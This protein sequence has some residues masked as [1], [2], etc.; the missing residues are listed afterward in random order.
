MP[1]YRSIHSRL[2]ISRR[3]VVWPYNISRQCANFVHMDHP[4]PVQIDISTYV[5]LVRSQNWMIGSKSCYSWFFGY[6][7]HLILITSLKHCPK[8][9]TYVKHYCAERLRNERKWR[10]NNVQ[11]AKSPNR[12]NL[13]GLYLRSRAYFLHPFKCQ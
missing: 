10:E 2:I 5:Q 11:E 6:V 13:L 9:E 8:C 4:W 1:T 3:M 7:N 12:I